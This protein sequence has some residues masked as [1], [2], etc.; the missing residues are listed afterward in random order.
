MKNA[1]VVGGGSWGSAFALHLAKA[2]LPVRLWIREPEICAQAVRTRQNRVFLPGHVF[3]ACASFHHDL[4]EAVTGA[5]TVFLAVPSLY[6]RKIYSRVAP[7]LRPG[8]GVISLTKGLEKKTLLRMSE[9]VASLPPA[10]GGSAR[11]GVLS[12]PSFSKETAEG[13]PTALV[14]AS[15][16]QDLARRI[17][18]RLSNSSWRIYTSRDV[19]GVEI[20]GALKNIIA[21]AAGLSDG[22]N[23]GF[24]SRA[25]LMTRGLAEIARLGTKLGARRETFAGLAGLGDLVLTCTGPLS[26]NRNVGLELGRGRSLASIV[27][28]MR[29]TAEGVPTT[30]SAR[31]LARR[32]GVDLPI[33]EEVYLVLYRR[34]N[35]RRAL[36]D[37]MSRTLKDEH[38]RL[39]PGPAAAAAVLMLAACLS[40]AKKLALQREK[41]PQYQFDK[42]ALCLQYNMVDEAFQ[43]ID[44]AL[45]LNP[46]FTAA[47]NL[48]GLALMIKGRPA[49]AI[50]ALRSSLEIDPTFSEGWNNLATA[51]DQNN[52]KEKAVESWKKAYDLDQNYNAS[53]NL[54]KTAFE[55]EQSDVA[56]DWIRKSIAKFPKSVLSYNLQGLILESLERYP[57]AIDSYQEAIKLAPT[58]LNVQFNLAMAF[59]R[60]KDYG[61][62]REILEKLLPLAKDELKLKVEEM[63]RRVGRY[64]DA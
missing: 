58:E 9:I 34:K 23:F 15:E 24:N 26:R 2:G 7:L 38:D 8:T 63:L 48:R 11:I 1:C 25:A 30:L 45:A 37:L 10:G 47:L 61:R 4:A 17:Q 60:K 27:G 3:P 22:M 12:G 44:K 29:E 31:A 14:M 51:Y 6:F 49:E 36:T 35:P 16:D 55:N 40:P 64:P 19:V 20:G 46:R 32:K 52:E 28:S 5:E 50:E 56:L 13:H 41:D 21:I 42:A 54:A 33:T 62:T 18:A 59:Y 39:S 43:Y 53:Y 57:E